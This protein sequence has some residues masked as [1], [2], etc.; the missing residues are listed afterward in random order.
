[1]K[2]INKKC[3]FKEY[4]KIFDNEFDTNSRELSK[5]VPLLIALFQDFIQNIIQL[6]NTTKKVHNDLVRTSDELRTTLEPY[7]IALLEKLQ[8]YDCE[9]QND[10]EQQAFVYG[11]VTAIH[12]K[13][14][15]RK[16]YRQYKYIR[17]KENRYNGKRGNYKTI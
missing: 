11:Y 15:S 9:I 13:A 5:D 6:T 3:K 7:Q 8:D 10:R 14:E 12:L 16:Q 2:I 17:K 1:M 4:L